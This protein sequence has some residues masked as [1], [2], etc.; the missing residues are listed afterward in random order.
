MA[1]DATRADDQDDVIDTPG[2]GKLHPFRKGDPRAAEYGRKGGEA[3]RARA[4][5]QASSA[6]A[7][8]LVLDEV[9]GTFSRETLGPDAAAAAGWVVA[10]VVAGKVPMRNADEAATLLRALV[11]VAR[12]EGGESTDMR[13]VAHIGADATAAVLALR[14]QARRAIGMAGVVDVSA[15]ATA[16]VDTDAEE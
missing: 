10:Q 12:L 6:R 16:V 4:A 8:A 9:R 15:A 11:D 13:V 7:V 2:G 3:R 1:A 5:A 14:D